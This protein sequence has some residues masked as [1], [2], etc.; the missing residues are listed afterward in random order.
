MN[1]DLLDKVLGVSGGISWVVSYVFYRLYRSRTD[2]ARQVKNIPIWEP[3]E[4]LLSHLTN[5][6]NLAYAAVEGVVKELNRTLHSR[7]GNNEGVIMETQLIEH[8][9]QRING[10]WSDVKK[11]LRDTTEYVPFA[12]KP[13]KDSGTDGNKHVVEVLDPG[14]A[15]RLRDE[16]ET[17][18]D[19]FEPHRSSL[20]QI[21]IDRLF[22]EVSKGLQESEKMLLTGTSLLGV[23]K[24]FLERGQ[25]KMAP[26]DD[27]SRTYI[28]TKMRLS[29]L[30]RHYEAQSSMYKVIALL[31]ALI[32]G[33]ILSIIVW[34]QTRAWL[35]RRKQRIQ[36]EDIRRAMAEAAERRR[37][38]I[39]VAR[40]RNS[41]EAE[42]DNTCVVCLTNQRQ[43]VA[44]NCGHISLCADCAEALHFPKKCPVCRAA[45]VRFM[46]IFHA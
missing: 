7:H 6:G 10:F 23:G 12:L 17:T 2:T 26:P 31:S 44:L 43:V 19:S 24:V 38:H 14:Q 36:F 15:A 21:G 32:G 25:I 39:S 45:V 13:V 37:V 20:V 46:P 3:G 28:L 8:K 42:I 9:S 1:L 18:H 27:L 40:N 33:G 4:D 5:D 29:E 11:V 22:G 35:E 41:E 34:R 16:L 30:V